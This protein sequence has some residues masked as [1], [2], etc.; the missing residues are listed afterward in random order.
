[1]VY[2]HL[3][4]RTPTHHKG[5]SGRFE[6]ALMAHYGHQGGVIFRTNTNCSF[7][8]GVAFARCCGERACFW[9]VLAADRGAA[10]G[11][12]SW[13]VSA[14]TAAAAFLIYEVVSHTSHNVTCPNAVSGYVDHASTT[15]H[16][17]RDYPV[18]GFTSAREVIDRVNGASI[19]ERR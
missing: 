9:G 15:S 7:R 8:S 18:N 19:H 4:A 14:C 16:H 17:V 12:V 5:A 1:M 3:T 6:P 2:R 10:A 11:W 13:Q